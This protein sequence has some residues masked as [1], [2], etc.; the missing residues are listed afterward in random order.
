MR[1]RSAVLALALFC[2]LP[3]P[4]A[5][6]RVVRFE[7][8]VVLSRSDTF[9]VE[10]RITYDFGSDQRHGIERWIPV[11]YGRGQAA[12]YHIDL[13]LQQAT[14]GTGARVPVQERR[15]G[16]NLVLRLG[17]P[18]TLVTGTREYR[19]R[20]TVRRGILY[21]QPHDE[22]YWNATGT[23]WE[24][25]ID[26]A[27]ARLEVPEGVDASGLDA[28]CFTGQQG[29]VESDC[30]VERK[31]GSLSFVAKRPLHAREGLTIVT[32][33]PKGILPVP[34]VAAQRIDRLTDYA[35]PWALLPFGTFAAMLLLWRTLG[36]DP[37]GREAIAA[38]YEPPAGLSPA[39]VGTVLD[40]SADLSDLTATIVDLAVKGFLRIEEQ[41]TKSFLFLTNRDYSLVKLREPEGLKPHEAA[42]MAALFDGATSVK[43]SDLRNRFYIH[44]PR[45]QKALYDELSRRDTGCFAGNPRRTRQGWVGLGFVIAVAGC[46]LAFPPELRAIGLSIAVSGLIVLVFA[47]AM[48][49]RTRVGRQ[50][51]R[52]ILGLR[53][54]LSRV[55]A[56]RLKREGVRTRE[57]FEAILPYAIVLG[58]AD[59]WANAFADIYTEPPKWYASPDHGRPFTPR[60]LV[61]HMGQ[62]LTTIGRAMTSQPRSA[63]SGSSG[64]GG[65]GFSGGGF[66]GGGGRS[67]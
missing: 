17:D 12:D 63:G 50:A 18:D 7:T 67:W 15:E 66:G 32:A 65:G 22:I 25:P 13:S 46:F 3:A 23:E 56:D 8:D 47:R 41:E 49:R 39:E 55:E 60:L 1:R 36:R 37:G 11:A 29:A 35:T 26:S 42:L 30:T 52:E 57:R 24:V 59:I 40:E 16:R 28:L 44:L 5:A 43:V 33:L 53:E 45:I 27:V 62:G 48:P 61:S 31:P 38:R 6:E 64:F 54:F 9:T 58:C 4:F 20:Y 34:S 19:L 2:G 10:E 14:D 21:L 51:L